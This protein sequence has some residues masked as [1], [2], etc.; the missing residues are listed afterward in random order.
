VVG[1]QLPSGTYRLN[2]VGNGFV[3]NGRAVDVANDGTQVNGFREFEFTVTSTAL[4]G[5][6]DGDG[7]VSGNDFLAWQRQLGSPAVPPDSG[8]D[9]DGSGTVDGPDLG[10]WRDNYGEPGFAA[11]VVIDSSASSLSAADATIDSSLVDLAI[12][13]VLARTPVTRVERPVFRPTVRDA[14]L[15]LGASAATPAL[16]AELGADSYDDLDALFA[17]L[18]DDDQPL[19]V[20]RALAAA[21]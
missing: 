9:G 6:Y 14:S 15:T 3:A 4:P 19:S 8:A 21:L 11:A 7:A 12:A 17:D 2:I 10:V 20:G 18:G 13:D 5:D 1:G 16:F